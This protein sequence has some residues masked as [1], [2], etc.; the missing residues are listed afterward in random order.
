MP[1]DQYPIGAG[2]LAD[3]VRPRDGRIVHFSSNDASGGNADLRR[4]G[5]GESHT[6]LDYDGGPGAIRRWWVTIAPRN[7]VEIHRQC[8]VR[9]YWDAETEPSVEVPISDFFGM[10]FGE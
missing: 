3:L 6:L 7:N 4:V 10:G 2:T 5:P 1:S 8:I 9:C